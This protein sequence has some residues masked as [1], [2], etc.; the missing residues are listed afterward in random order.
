MYLSTCSPTM[1]WWYEI[2][3]IPQGIQPLRKSSFTTI[4]YIEILL[5][6]RSGPDF[7]DKFTFGIHAFS[8]F[9]PCTFTYHLSKWYYRWG[10]I[11]FII[12]KTILTLNIVHGQ[13]SNQERSLNFLFDMTV[14]LFLPTMTLR[15]LTKT[16]TNHSSSSPRFAILWLSKLAPIKSILRGFSVPS[17]IIFL[18]TSLIQR[19][20]H[21]S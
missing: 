14:H 21:N 8:S 9:Q 15:M 3:H 10:W 4:N 7:Q 5:I 1:F 11:M 6:R 17:A 13:L 19:L 16:A 18:L 20:L 2:H 12:Y